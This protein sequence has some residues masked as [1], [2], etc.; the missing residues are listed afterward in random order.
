M[1]IVACFGI[2]FKNASLGLCQCEKDEW[3]VLQKSQWS[4]TISP[5][6]NIYMD[7]KFKDKASGSIPVSIEEGLQLFTDFGLS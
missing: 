1:K 5:Y 2:I 6:E 4:A 7:V 3:Q